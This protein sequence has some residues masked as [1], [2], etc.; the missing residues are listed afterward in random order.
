MAV[1]IAVIDTLAQAAMDA[2]VSQEDIKKFTKDFNEEMHRQM[3][4]FGETKFS[5]AKSDKMDVIIENFISLIKNPIKISKINY[6]HIEQFTA[7]N[8]TK[9]NG[10]IEQAAYNSASEL[11]DIVDNNHGKDS[12]E[13]LSRLVNDTAKFNTKTIVGIITA[14][15]EGGIRQKDPDIVYSILDES[16][17]DSAPET[18]HEKKTYMAKGEAYNVLYK[19][20]NLLIKAAQEKGVKARFLNEA[21]TEWM[22]LMYQFKEEGGNRFK[23]HEIHTRYMNKLIDLIGGKTTGAQGAYNDARAQDSKV[24]VA[25]DKIFGLFGCKTIGEMDAKLGK[26]SADAKYLAAITDKIKNA[27]TDLEKEKLVKQFQTKYKAIFGVDYN[28]AIMEKRDELLEK[29][30]KVQMYELLQPVFNDAT[31]QMDIIGIKSILDKCKT[32][33]GVG[34]DGKNI[35]LTELVNE[36]VSLL[37]LALQFDGEISVRIGD[38]SYDI[39]TEE[40]AYRFVLRKMEVGYKQE[41]DS[42]LEGTNYKQMQ[43]DLEQLNQAVYGT[44][45][46]GKEVAEFNKNQM[47][48]QSYSELGIDIGVTILTSYIPVVGEAKVGLMAEK[49]EKLALSTSKFK[50]MYKTMAT[51][52]RGLQTGFKGSKTLQQGQ[53]VGEMV[54]IG[55]CSVRIIKVGNKTIQLGR[56][57]N[58]TLE[59]AISGAYNSINSGAVVM[60]VHLLEGHSFDESYEAGKGMAIFGMVSAAGSFAGKMTAGIALKMGCTKEAVQ[61]ALAFVVEQGGVFG[62][63]NY[64]TVAAYIKEKQKSDPNF[65]FS[66]MSI[67]ELWDVLVSDENII[68]NLIMLTMTVITHSTQ[69]MKEKAEAE[70]NLIC[71]LGDTPEAKMRAETF[72]KENPSIN[73]NDFNNWLKTVNM[74]KIADTAPNIKLY[75]PEE[76]ELFLKMHFLRGTKEFS[77]QELTLPENI[78]DFLSKNPVTGKDLLDLF[79]V[80]PNTKRDVGSLPESWSQGCDAGIEGRVRTIMEKY[81]KIGNNNYLSRHKTA[82]DMSIEEWQNSLG[83][84]D[85]VLTKEEMSAFAKE[86]SEILN[87]KVLVDVCGF[88]NYK[89]V[90]KIEVEDAEPVAFAIFHPGK[91]AHSHVHGVGAEIGIGLFLNSH[92]TDYTHFY[93]GKV[94]DNTDLN[95]YSVMQYAKSRGNSK[96]HQAAEADYSVSSGHEGSLAQNKRGGL[97]IDYGGVKITPKDDTQAW[98]LT[99]YIVKHKADKQ[100]LHPVADNQ[101]SSVKSTYDV[102]HKYTTGDVVPVNPDAKTSSYKFKNS[103][104]AKDFSPLLNEETRNSGISTK[105]QIGG[106]FIKGT[107]GQPLGT[108]GVGNCAVLCLYN[109]K[110]NTTAVYHAFP[111]KHNAIKSMQ[112]D[113]NVIMPEGFDKVF[114]VPGRDPETA[115][116][117]LNLLKSAQNINQNTQVEFRHTTTGNNNQIIFY[118]GEVFELPLE[119]NMPS[120]KICEEP[121]NYYIGLIRK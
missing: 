70:N 60:G 105:N 98:S 97:I 92:S 99:D 41:A 86:L 66:K 116:T 39:K 37:T 93:F 43:I 56:V 27:K 52:C 44:T 55:D 14:Y 58:L 94:P 63:A 78:T 35:Y 4:M 102:H 111:V 30:A 73:K 96:L 45:N 22:N 121:E 40:D 1:M 103:Q 112:A 59:T 19:M 48:L 77:N 85:E 106:C 29:T 69:R 3:D 46:I 71:A 114:I 95:G 8:K 47:M 68:N 26:Y 115:N 84:K 24:G 65:S 25:V 53:A 31:K 87:K 18:D 72:F 16:H 51:T 89:T 34:E 13:K 61:K 67:E 9:V 12:M 15:N 100:S 74:D 90:F 82:S 64:E 79:I 76:R 5:R 83:Q 42:A 23:E 7:E 62:F 49:L 54:Q 117:A 21:R 57:A 109:S 32:V 118:Q 10:D 75:T 108:S 88:G 113:I 80:F 110:T 38:K 104:A 119:N 28:P 17:D 6:K 20:I 36:Q 120:F 107:P 101:L 81:R 50:K 11:Y 33:V 2:G 91:G